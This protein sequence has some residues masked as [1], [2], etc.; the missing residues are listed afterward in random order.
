MRAARADDAAAIA[1][2]W[3]EW[4]REYEQLDGELF[5]VPSGNGL[6]TWFAGRIESA[7]EDQAWLVAERGGAVVGFLHAEVWR[8]NEEAEWSPLVEDGTT[9]LRVGLLGVTASAR[10]LGVAAALSRAAE[11]W[12]R[13]RGA[14]R[15]FVIAMSDSPTAIPFYTGQGFRPFTT[16]FWKALS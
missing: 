14:V 1:S 11:A 5:R 2:L 8:P 3:I 16:G 9:T 7:T 4:G 6:V 15:A 12:G 13:E 10:R